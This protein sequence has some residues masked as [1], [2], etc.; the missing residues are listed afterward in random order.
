[1]PFRELGI[2]KWIRDPI[3]TQRDLSRATWYTDGSMM[4]GVWRQMRVTDFGLVVGSD[5]GELLGYDLAPRPPA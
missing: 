5:E 4:G 1:M 2:F 3:A